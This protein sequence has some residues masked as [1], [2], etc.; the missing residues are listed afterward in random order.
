MNLNVLIKEAIASVNED[1]KIDELQ[2]L[3]ESTELFTLLDS[4][5]T[6]DLIFELESRLK[7]LTGRYIS[8]ADEHSMDK[9]NTPFKNIATLQEYLQKKVSDE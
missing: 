1:L 9:D 4:L 5:G 2:N 6:L 8:V 7:E 3:N